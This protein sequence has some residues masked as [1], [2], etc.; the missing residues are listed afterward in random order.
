[1]PIRI[2]TSGYSYKDW[3][4]PV[5]P[6]TAPAKDF[7]RL[8]SQL[9]S[10]TE[11]N[12]SYYRQPQARTLE[13]MLQMVPEGFVFTIKG[14]RTLTH[15][16]GV[17]VST[18]THVF[19][20]G[21]RP[22]VE[23]GQLGSVVLQFPYSFHY[24]TSSRKHLDA[25]C[26]E[27]EGYPAAVEFRNSEWQR[28]S[29]YSGLRKRGVALVNV[30]EPLLPKLPRPTALVTAPHAYV[31]FHGRNAANW[32]NGDNTTRYDYKYQEQEL[33]EWLPRLRK[34]LDS[35]STTVMVLFNNHFQGKAVEDARKLREMLE[36]TG[37]VV[38]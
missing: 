38:E 2:G 3:I 37:I 30:D 4:G 12:F 24:T 21:I 19:K 26:R 6:P 28:D 35:A 1:M 13:R 18:D 29:V 33:G 10:L 16:A 17:N 20:E 15:E 8:Y 25:L 7:L 11:L 5:Y 22:L 27:F 34:M 32:W 36:E 23:A 9:F 14:H 31:R